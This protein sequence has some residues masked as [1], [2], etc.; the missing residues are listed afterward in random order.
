[1]VSD[2]ITVEHRLYYKT[3]LYK[4]SGIGSLCLKEIQG[5]ASIKNELFLA[6]SEGLFRSGL[7]VLAGQYREASSPAACIEIRLWINIGLQ[8][9][10]LSTP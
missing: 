9:P 2:Q 6:P 3:A 10:E 4:F 1:M 5:Q 8:F 7:K